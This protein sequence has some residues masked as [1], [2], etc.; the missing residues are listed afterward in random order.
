MFMGVVV[1]EVV[2]DAGRQHKAKIDTDL[3]TTILIVSTETSRARGLVRHACRS[4][5]A[6]ARQICI[7]TFMSC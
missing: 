5:S 4:A 7:G 6:H 2:S 3:F 1:V